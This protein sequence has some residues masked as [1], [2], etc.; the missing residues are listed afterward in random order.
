M[1]IDRTR[2]GGQVLECDCDRDQPRRKGN[3]FSLEPI[4]IPAAVP[5]LGVMADGSRIGT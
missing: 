4:G 1:S 2:P 3:L 5:I